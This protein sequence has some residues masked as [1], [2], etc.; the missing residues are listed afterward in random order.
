VNLFMD[1]DKPH[2]RA[3]LDRYREQYGACVMSDRFDVENAL[4]GQW[5]LT[6]ERGTLRVAITLAPTMPPKVQYLNVTPVPPPSA[7]TTARGCGA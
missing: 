2:R 1:V 4:R 7:T 3:Q 5:N 6:C